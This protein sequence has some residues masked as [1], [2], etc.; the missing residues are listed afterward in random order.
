MCSRDHSDCL[1]APSLAEHFSSMFQLFSKYKDNPGPGSDPPALEDAE[2][3]GEMHASLWRFLL[4]LDKR[5][6]ITD[7][8]VLLLLRYITP[9]IISIE[10]LILGYLIGAP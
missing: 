7:E 1:I 5:Q 2:P 9:L 4:H 10:L 3:L 6:A 8:R